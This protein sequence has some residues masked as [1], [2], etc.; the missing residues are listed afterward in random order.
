MMLTI[1][2]ICLVGLESGILCLVLGA[3][4]DQESDIKRMN[5]VVASQQRL[6]GGMA[7]HNLR[8]SKKLSEIEQITNPL[9]WRAS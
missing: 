7:D 6:I 1:V 9:G 3:L 2:L 4:K 8:I 5:A